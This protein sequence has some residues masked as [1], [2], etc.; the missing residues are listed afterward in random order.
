[1]YSFSKPFSDFLNTLPDN[2]NVENNLSTRLHLNKNN[3]FNVLHDN[4]QHLRMRMYT[5][6]FTIYNS[7]LPAYNLCLFYYHT[8]LTI[9]HISYGS[10]EYEFIQKGT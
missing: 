9:F 5:T 6:Y 1:M 10:E 7:K 4:Y 8:Y 3:I 2:Y